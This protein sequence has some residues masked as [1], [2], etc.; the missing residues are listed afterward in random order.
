MNF[1]LT[2]MMIIVKISIV[3]TIEE[4]ITVVANIIPAEYFEFIKKSYETLKRKF[5]AK[6]DWCNT[7]MMDSKETWWRLSS[8]CRWTFNSV[9][10]MTYV[11]N[12]RMGYTQWQF[13]SSN[14]ICGK[15]LQDWNTSVSLIIQTVLH[16]NS[17]HS[18]LGNH[19]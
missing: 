13:N 5:S 7:S 15:K 2:T 4:E 16:I 8:L 14:H 1:S 18:E 19:R 3:S 12:D 11:E 9:A 10:E 17:K 6:W